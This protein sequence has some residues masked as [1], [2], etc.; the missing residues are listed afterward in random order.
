MNKKR[1][2]TYLAIILLWYLIR[3]INLPSLEINFNPI[4]WDKSQIIKFF[5]L[6]IIS[7]AVEEYFIR[8]RLKKRD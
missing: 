6:I 5:V 3:S 8:K 7:I 4:T 1:I 2:I